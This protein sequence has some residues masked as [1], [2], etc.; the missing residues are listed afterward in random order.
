MQHR[1]WKFRLLDMKVGIEKILEY[2]EEIESA[3]H[4]ANESKT[5]DAC[6]R[7]FQILGDAAGKVPSAVRKEIDSIPWKEIRGMRNIL[8]HEYFGVSPSILWGTIKSDLPP[9]KIELDRVEKLLNN[10]V[11][12]WKI[13]PPG[14]IYVREAKVKGHLRKGQEVKEHLRSNYCRESTHSLKDILTFREIQEIA[15]LFF[16]DLKGPPS[17]IDLDFDTLGL[18]FDPLIRGWTQYWNDVLKPKEKLDP[19]LIKALIASESSFNSELGKK[20]RNK[21]KGLM[22]IMPLTIRSLNGAKGELKDHIIEFHEKD[23]YDPNL[24]IAAGIRW[25][26]RK[27]EMA[28]H[29][30]GREASWE[31]A[32]EEY[33]D[34]LKSKDKNPAKFKKGMAP[35]LNLY[36]QLE[37]ANK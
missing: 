30:L 34:F 26:F 29:K 19:N 18:E 11:H 12:P 35:F 2:C 27:K 16:K 6:V 28:K 10:P 9:L 22:Q 14:E 20:K 37:A 5:L 13:C 31:E 23:I 1:N 32:V 4:F 3:E 36:K 8:V 7:N 25:L 17:N 15:D 21:A 33:K 24:N